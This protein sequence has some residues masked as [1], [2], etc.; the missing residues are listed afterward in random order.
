MLNMTFLKTLVVTLLSIITL[1]SC[2]LIQGDKNKHYGYVLEHQEAI[3]TAEDAINVG[4]YHKALTLLEPY[5][6]PANAFNSEY[7]AFNDESVISHGDREWIVDLLVHAYWENANY[8]AIAKILESN[9]YVTDKAVWNCRLLGATG[10]FV[11]A[12]T[13]YEKEGMIEEAYRVTLTKGFLKP[14]AYRSR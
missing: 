4:E 6:L 14:S 3:M 13:C 1:A 11:S 5:L 7:A 2:T 12:E 10:D 9:H 8:P